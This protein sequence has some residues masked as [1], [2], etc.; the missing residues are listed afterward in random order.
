MNLP[1]ISIIIPC[2][3]EEKFIAMCLDSIIA[4]DYP[5]DK[6]EIFVVDGMSEDGTREI[7]KKYAQQ[8]PNIKL[9]D[10]PSKIVPTAMNLGIKN[11]KGNIIIR[12]DAHNEYSKDYIS[13]IVYWLDKSGADNVG[14][15]W[16]TKP[17]SNT[18]ISKAIA[19]SLSSPFG[20]GNAMFRIGLK[21]SKYV[22]TVPFG[23]YRREVFNKIGLF[24]ENLIRNQ[25]IEF[26]LRL[27]RLGGRILLTSDIV[28]YYYAQSTLKGLAKQNFQNGF[29]VIYSN[30]FSKL[31]FSTR[32]L[33]PFV[34]VSSLLISLILSL[35][36]PIFLSLLWLITGIYIVTNL[37]F[38]F[39]IATRKGMKYLMP[40]FL[41]FATLHFSYGLGSIFGLLRLIKD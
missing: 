39:K 17:S 41:S 15:I 22:D 38:S 23:A 5:K 37:F 12:M 14:G 2:R 7:I 9:L 3:N 20:V 18:L 19:L 11:A 34:F 24:N 1:F 8:Y 31:P 21:E 13:K 6:L 26:N 32:H 4:N 29:W 25:D 27:K 35:F 40:V 33:V 16:I 28:S 10:N 30:K 36:S